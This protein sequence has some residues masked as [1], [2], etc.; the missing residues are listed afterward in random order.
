M[1]EKLLFRKGT[2]ELHPDAN[3]NFQMN[4]LVMWSGAD[5]E[6]VKAVAQKI[7]D[8]GS[9]VS[10]FLALGEKALSEGRTQQAMAY[11]RGAEF[12]IYD[13]IEKKRRTG[14]KANGLFYEHYSHVFED[15]LISR[16]SVPYGQGYLPVWVARPEDNRSAGTILLHG[17]FD[18]CIEEF[19]G[20]IL[21]L[22]QRGYNVYL[23]DGPGQG[24]VLKKYGIP[25]TYEWERPVKSILDHF[26][27][28]GVTIVGLSLGGMLAPRAA[29]FEPR[30][31][32]V[33]AWGVMP[34]F[35]EVVLS[36]RPRILRLLAEVALRLRLKLPINLSSERE[37][38]RDTMAEWGIKHGMY[39]FGV[40]SPY[41]YLATA[42]K[43]QMLNI[44]ELITQDFLLL[45]STRDHF[46]PSGFYKEVI[47][48]LVN[49]KSLTFRLFTEREEA[50]NHCNA[51]NTRLA[52]DTIID[53]IAEMSR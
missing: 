28:E 22:R 23:F 17:G 20:A 47:D 9:W 14:E 8:L 51:G 1:D 43:Y 40:D 37:M 35:Q 52:L 46:I 19:L 34:N 50:E 7:T 11:F 10:T 33:V 31:E 27:L 38:A 15:G 4:R 36:T 32:R 41:D 30:I 2:F 21:Y 12:F 39:V 53:W 5:L 3:F 16:E 6:E 24:E 25:M 18:S 45:G 26:G 49:V 29:A 44:A 13:D 48:S 42:D